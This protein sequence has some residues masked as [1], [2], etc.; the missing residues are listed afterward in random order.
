MKDSELQLLRQRMRQARRDIS[1][2]EREF[3]ERA[4][5][6]QL[7]AMAAFRDAGCIALYSAFDGEPK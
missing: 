6:Q 7:I 4:I 2:T 5:N 1:P 3:A